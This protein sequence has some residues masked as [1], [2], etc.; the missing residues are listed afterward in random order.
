MTDPEILSKIETLFQKYAFIHKDVL[1]EDEAAII[2]D[3]E[4]CSLRSMCSRGEIAFHKP[5][6]RKGRS[7]KY[8]LKTDLNEYMT[9]G[10]VAGEKDIESMASTYNFL[11]R[12][13]A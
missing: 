10:R 4:V 13:T 3:V 7:K 5:G 11:K 12:K 2:L 9:R 1:T 8:F 6:G